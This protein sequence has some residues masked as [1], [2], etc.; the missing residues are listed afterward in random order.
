MERVRARARTIAE[1][2]RRGCGFYTC[3]CS[4]STFGVKSID[5]TMSWSRTLLAVLA[6]GALAGALRPAALPRTRSPRSVALRSSSDAAPEE[7]ASTACEIRVIGPKGDA[8]TIV[9][10]R[11][12]NLRKVLLADKAELYSWMTTMSNCNGGGQCGTCAVIVEGGA[13]GPRFE[14]EEGKLAKKAPDA[15]LACQTV[16]EGAAA[17]VVLQP[18]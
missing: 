3:T 9:A 15:R 11:G 6:A 7:E 5:A 2:P 1:A 12:D 14:W 10:E 8:R 16:V 18:K 17:T 4:T 13:F